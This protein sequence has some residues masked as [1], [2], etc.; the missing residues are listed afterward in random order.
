MGVGVATGGGFQPVRAGV[1]PAGEEAHL[2][3]RCVQMCTGRGGGGGR[4]LR[5]QAEP[6]R[7]GFA[8]CVGWFKLDSGDKRGMVSLE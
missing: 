6:E 3:G 4:G 7:E 1:R 8:V 2:G 5:R